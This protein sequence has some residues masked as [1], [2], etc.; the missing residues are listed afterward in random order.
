MNVRDATPADA[1][2]MLAFVEE[3]FD[4]LWKRPFPRPELGPGELDGKIALVVE[5]EGE[6]I[7]CAYGELHDN[8]VAHLNLVY[9]IPERRR[10][11]VAK[12]LIAGFLDRA[13]AEADHVTLDVDTTNETGR[14]A[15]QRLGFTD[16]ALSMSTPIDSLQ[17]RLAGAHGGDSYASIHVQ[18]DDAEG[19]EAPSAVAVAATSTVSSSVPVEPP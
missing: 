7:G 1:E 8:R 19:V 4:E 18:T 13:K 6:A 5:D 14:T 12:L 17:L 2:T 11:G 10:E 16:W 3:S 15:W 9:V